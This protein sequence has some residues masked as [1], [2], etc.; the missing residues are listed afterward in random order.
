MVLL[1]KKQLPLLTARKVI[2]FFPLENKNFH[3]TTLQQMNIRLYSKA[4]WTL[5]NPNQK[6]TN[7][8]PISFPCVCMDTHLIISA[9]AFQISAVTYLGQER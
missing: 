2:H 5:E 8:L 3:K 9:S 4:F 7:T 6:L 1:P